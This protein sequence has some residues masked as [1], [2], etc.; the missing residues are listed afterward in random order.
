MSEKIKRA[1]GEEKG[2]GLG[3]LTRSGG[4]GRGRSLKLEESAFTYCR[5]FLPVAAV[6]A[7]WGKLGILKGVLFWRGGEYQKKERKK[8]P[9]G[10]LPVEGR[11]LLG[12]GRGEEETE[13][14]TKIW[15]KRSLGIGEKRSGF[16]RVR[17][18][19]DPPLEKKGKAS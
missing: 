8:P 18:H 15:G 12:G 13:F 11:I 2:P 9:G 10:L 1:V 6:E 5:T 16:L 14:K 7:D 19:G 4:G 3:G 17:Q